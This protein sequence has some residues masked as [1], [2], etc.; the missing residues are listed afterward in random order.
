MTGIPRPGEIVAVPLD[1]PVPYGRALE[2]QRRLA[3]ERIEGRSDED[4]LLLMEHAP[5]LTMGRNA[6]AEHLVAAGD[7]LERRGIERVEIERGGDVT[8]HGPGQLVG[9]PIL[10]L[11]QHQKDLHWYLRAVEDA[12]VAALSELALPA[13]RVPGHTGVWVGDRKRV[14]AVEGPEPGENVDPEST[15]GR[16]GTLDEAIAAGAIRKIASIGVHVS[17]WVTW[18]G[19]ALNH[20]EEPLENFRLI[21]PCGIP[22]VRMTSLASEGV[23]VGPKRVRDA[24]RAG[25][26]SA[27]G[28]SVREERRDLLPRAGDAAGSAD[29]DAS[30]PDRAA[31]PGAGDT[32]DRRPGRVTQSEPAAGGTP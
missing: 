18:H 30:S 26:A 6:G 14:R 7:A 15:A 4:L 17:R 19:F 13:F 8:Y 1:G 3:R 28:V 25:F 27:F 10:D 29:E 22:G 32:P 12:L 5:V 9:Y 23:V 2:L 16:E 21:V 20:T 24:V 11:R 31:A